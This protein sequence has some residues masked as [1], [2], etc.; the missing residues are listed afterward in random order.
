MKKNKLFIILLFS[1]I[2][3]FFAHADNKIKIEFSPLFSLQNGMLYEYVLVNDYSSKSTQKLSELDWP[4]NNISY[5]GIQF[6]TKIKFINFHL[7]YAF[8]FN[9]ASGNMEDFDWQDCTFLGNKCYYNN[10]SLCTNKSINE[11]YLNNANV[12]DFNIRFDINPILDFHILPFIGFTYNYYDFIGKNGYGWYG[13]ID[14]TYKDKN[15]AYYDSEA[16]YYPKGELCGIEYQKNIYDI[17]IGFEINYILFDRLSLSSSFAVSPF[18]HIYSIDFHHSNMEGT[19]GQYYHDLMTGY[20]KHFL[21]SEKVS[22]KFNKYCSMFV[23]FDFSIQNLIEGKTY[24][25]DSNTYTNNNILKTTF[26]GCEGK[27]WQFTTGIT[28]TF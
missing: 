8:G 25:S 7:S 10:S 28:F 22:F 23:N 11:N 26:A 18:M 15:V 20:F 3:S 1:F 21:L 24:K 5:A 27:Y 17:Y 19:R 14:H 9:K 16:I 6:D 4:V 12:F 13:D 2:L